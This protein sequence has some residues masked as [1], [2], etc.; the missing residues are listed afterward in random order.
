[1]STA[2]LSTKEALTAWDAGYEWAY[3]NPE[4]AQEL[5]ADRALDAVFMA[6]C[7]DQG[8][9]Y[10]EETDPCFWDRYHEVVIAARAGCDFQSLPGVSGYPNDQD[11]G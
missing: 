9:T 1:M 2:T 6:V 10:D 3:A 8:W 4:R 7:E 5:I 11:N